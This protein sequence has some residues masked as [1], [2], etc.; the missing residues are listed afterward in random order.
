MEIAGKKVVDAKS[1]LRIEITARD[2][3][4]GK[5]KDPASC[6]AARAILRGYKSDGVKSA[7]VHLGRVYVEHDDKWIR[8]KTPTSLRAEIVSFDRGN[9]AQFMAGVYALQKIAPTDRLGARAAIT[10]ISG[11]KAT[12]HKPRKERVKI[13]RV[14]HQ[15][16]GVRA[17][18]ANR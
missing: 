2:A 7:R 8:Y 14:H 10:K 4:M 6:A 15:I 3:E 5:T 16:E 9:S 11:P 12:R 1:P 13:A 17:K 18:G